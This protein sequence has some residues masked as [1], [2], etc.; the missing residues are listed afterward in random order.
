MGKAERA[1]RGYKEG[2]KEMVEI[3]ERVFGGLRRW[4]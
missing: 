3:L 4:I 2:Q 1:V